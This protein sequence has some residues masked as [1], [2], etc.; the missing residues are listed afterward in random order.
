MNR[1]S[2]SP[3]VAIAAVFSTIVAAT[4]T[5]PAADPEPIRLD[6]GLVSGGTGS[7]GEIRVFKGIPFAAPPIGALRWKAPQPAAHWDGVRKA[8]EFGPRCM[9]GGRG[10]Q[11]PAPSEDCL[12]LNVWTGAK[13]AAERR[14]VMIFTYGGSFTGG[15]GSEPRYDGEALAKKG[16]VAITYNYRLG[17]FG[18][19][20]H[21]ELTRESGHS[22]S[23]NQGLA[24]AIAALKW[25]Q[26]NASAFGGDPQRVTIFGESAGGIIVAALVASPE[27]KGLFQRAVS[28]S[29]S[30]MGTRMVPTPTL[31]QAEAEA[32]KAAAAAG[33]HSLAE[34]RA[35]PAEE[36]QKDFRGARPIV[37]GYLVP[38][39]LSLTF[40]N[41]RQQN[42]D[43]LLGSNKDEGTFFV[44][45][46]G[47]ADAYVKDVRQRF[48]E[49]AD[50]YLK[51]YPGG[52][53][54]EAY[55]SQLAGYR[56]EVTWLMRTWAE[57][58]A[59]RGQSKSYVYY[60]TQEPP[61][62]TGQQNRGAT[63]TAELNYVFNNLLPG[64][65][66]TEA[67]RSLAD[68]MS[69]YWVNFAVT[70]DPN[71][72]GLP[73]WPVYR[74]KAT[75]RAMVLGG[76]KVEPEAPPNTAMLA[77]YDSLWKQQMSPAVGRT[78]A[79]R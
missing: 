19:L 63:H 62:A 14:P 13:S 69:S 61:V 36:I 59:R 16:V 57:S 8:D 21:P 66:W 6:T 76:G 24:D 47:A 72:K 4:A 38:E 65:A 40:A 60:F 54:E 3:L 23:G 37:E 25:V 2:F 9:Q 77:L 52:S 70:G 1:S 71:G 30:W 17:P 28:E 79:V 55:T 74:D 53:P 49:M 43:T 33:A 18:W 73:V 39:D 48:G 22:A 44:R 58:Q 68:T 20:A 41:G 75:G 10:N 78:A 12:Y 51:M 5:L 32:V 11:Q 64:P 67:D 56:D 27:A 31:A 15:S 34:M 50:S 42:V 35:K 46:A 29:A 45:S 26:K 7:S